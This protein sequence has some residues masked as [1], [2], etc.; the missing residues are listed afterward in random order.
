MK[1]MITT[2]A[3]A[4]VAALATH[5]QD[6]LIAGW[7]FSNVPGDFAGN[8]IKANMSDL[9]P[10]DGEADA[11]ASGTLFF[12]GQFGST[13][14]DNSDAFSLLAGFLSLN[15]NS[16]ILTPLRPFPGDM[17]NPLP[18]EPGQNHLV[19]S[20][21]SFGA[22]GPADPSNGSMVFVA[23]APA[24]QTFGAGTYVFSFAV[25]ND[26]AVGDTIELSASLDGINYTS[27][28]TQQVLTN[29]Q[30]GTPMSLKTQ[31]GETDL[32]FRIT[33]PVIGFGAFLFDNVQVVGPAPGSA[34]ASFWSLSPVLAG[35]WRDTA[36][37]Y[38]ADAGIGLIHDSHWPF[39]LA[40]GI[41]DT[42]GF[43]WLWID[44]TGSRSGFY[45]YVFA[46]DYWIYGNANVGWYYRFQGSDSG[47]KPFRR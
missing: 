32:Y 27:F 2:L 7:S 43:T 4:T 14:V 41:G 6:V 20:D 33:L 34:P 5:A 31:G 1:R 46:G 40:A 24:G 21:G 9:Y 22:G 17:T 13:F 37:G 28:G 45:A 35:G 44:P 23:H 38:P 18:G 26:F 29:D 39:V 10:Q 30:L 11:G 3:A 36:A 8:T 16:D 42:T 47:W 19:V 25:G 12:N 15:S